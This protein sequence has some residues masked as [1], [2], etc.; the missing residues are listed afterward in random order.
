MK[1]V[2]WQATGIV[3]TVLIGL[4]LTGSAAIGGKIAALNAALGFVLYAL[5]ERIWARV[6]WGRGGETADG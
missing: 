4:L 5:Y 3:S 1:A 2:L 6:R